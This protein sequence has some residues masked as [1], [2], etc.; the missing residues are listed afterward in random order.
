MLNHWD[1]PDGTIERGYAGSSLWKWYEL[2][3]RVDPRYTGLCPGQCVIGNQWNGAQQ[4]QCQRTVHVAGV[5]CESGGG[6]ERD[7]KIWD[8][9]LSVRVFCCTENAGRTYNLRSARPAST[10]LVEGK[11]SSDL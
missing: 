8:Q 10:R 7:A 9:N 5:H 6:G 1:N 11:G 4:C 3:E 2:P